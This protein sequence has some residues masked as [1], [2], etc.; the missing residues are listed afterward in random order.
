MISFSHYKP[1]TVPEDA[2]CS[3]SV[4]SRFSVSLFR[5]RAG[6]PFMFLWELVM[7]TND[8]VENEYERV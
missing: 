3:V 2:A 7:H 5:V 1:S 4:V 8:G 6:L